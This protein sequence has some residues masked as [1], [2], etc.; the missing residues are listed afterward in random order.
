MS[1]EVTLQYNNKIF[2]K[3]QLKKFALKLC[4][5]LNILPSDGYAFLRRKDQD[6]AISSKV[7]IDELEDVCEIGTTVS[8][9]DL[10]YNYNIIKLSCTSCPNALNVLYVV[11]GNLKYSERIIFFVENILEITRLTE[12]ISDL[13]DRHRQDTSDISTGAIEPPAEEVKVRLGDKGVDQSKEAF[14]KRQYLEIDKPVLKLLKLA[15]ERETEK[16]VGCTL[17]KYLHQMIRAHCQEIM[18]CNP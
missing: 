7:A 9:L 14:N 3:G 1:T 2:D 16:T 15:Y 12:E 8:R 6:F 4:R 10:H 18:G 11:N 17:E 13:T 5:F